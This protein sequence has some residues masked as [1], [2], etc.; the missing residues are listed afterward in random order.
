MFEWRG[1]V[2]YMGYYS[3]V[4]MDT[5]HIYSCIHCY[6]IWDIFDKKFELLCGEIVCYYMYIDEF[7]LKLKGFL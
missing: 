7:Q 3:W 1:I 4:N 6:F 2:G 5:E